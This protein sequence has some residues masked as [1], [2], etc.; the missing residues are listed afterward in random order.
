MLKT[1]RRYQNL[2]FSLSQ[3]FIF[4]VFVSNLIAALSFIISPHAYSS[5]FDLSGEPGRVAVVGTGILFLMWQVPYVIALLNPLKYYIS[6]WEATIMQAIGL[7]AETILLS[8]IKPGHTTIE[9]SIRR[10]IWFDLAGLVLL[11]IALG[12]IAKLRKGNADNGESF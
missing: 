1:N 10:F 11:I 2:Y 8:T 3:L 6:L 9:A 7:G 5:G 12:L 4:A